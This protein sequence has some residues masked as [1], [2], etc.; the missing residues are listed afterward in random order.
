MKHNPTA[1]LVCM[2][3]SHL[4]ALARELDKKGMLKYIFTGYPSS[5][6][7]NEDIPTDK[8]K[9]FPYIQPL[10]KFLGKWVLLKETRF[11]EE[12]SWLARE[13]LDRHVAKH[14]P[15]SDVLFALASCGLACGQK[16]KE[17][18]MK[19]ICDTGNS[20][21]RYMDAILREEFKRWGE[22]FSGINK[23]V[24]A[25]REFEYEAAEMITVPSTFVYSSFVE[26]GVPETKLCKIPFGVDLGRFE[27]VSD[28]DP[29]GFDIL[30]VGKLSFR[31]GVPD[32]IEAFKHLSHPHKRL[33]IVGRMD[34][35]MSRYLNKHRLP[36]GIEFLSHITQPKLKNIMSR[37][38]VMVLPSIEEG[39]AKVQAQALACG[40][41]V[42]GT[43]HSGAKDVFVHGQEGFIVPIRDS[44]IIAEKLQLLADNPQLR[45]KMSQAALERTKDMG[46]G[47]WAEYGNQIAQVMKDLVNKS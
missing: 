3:R 1:T 11:L 39:L 6:F 43:P 4:S 23:K 12:L 18:G 32:L 47:G 10:Y 9:T 17:K 2:G 24:L 29:K 37:S 15:Q 46:M 5:K 22:P 13:T 26:M 7:L 25:K 33:R 41:P 30:F 21:I 35:E 14:L 40:C 20:H 38:H 34:P 8:L 16:A 27:K 44:K 45:Q 42:I 19:Y 31:K 36:D 28:P